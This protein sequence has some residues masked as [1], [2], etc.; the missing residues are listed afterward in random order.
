MSRKRAKKPKLPMK[1]C[2]ECGTPFQPYRT[3]DK[4]CSGL[5]KGRFWRKVNKRL[6]F[7]AKLRL[8]DRRLSALESLHPEIKT[9]S[10]S[11]KNPALEAKGF[12]NPNVDDGA[13]GS[14]R[15]ARVQGDGEVAHAKIQE[16]GKS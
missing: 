15:N 1:G 4:F 8:F 5:C 10:A 11:P 6:G 2:Q 9:F 14:P 7:G 13:I 3:R 16:G 12:G